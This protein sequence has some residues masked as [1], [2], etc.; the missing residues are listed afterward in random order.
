M[1]GTQRIGP[2]AGRTSAIYRTRITH[3]RRAAAHHYFEHRSYCWYVDVDNLPRLPRWLR[4]AAQFDARDHFSGADGESLRQRVDSFLAARG[5]T[6]PGGRITALL[7]ARVFG[8]AFNPLSIYWCHDRD[9]VLRHVVAE[10]H[11]TRGER[12]AYLLPPADDPALVTKALYASP[13]HPVDGH[14]LVRAP[15]PEKH[16]DVTISLHRGDQPAFVATLRGSR[17]RASAGTLLGLQLVAPLAPLW[18]RLDMRVQAA[19]L[20]LRGVPRFP[21]RPLS[22]SVA[23]ASRPTRCVDITCLSGQSV[24]S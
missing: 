6:V 1:E 20:W 10:V 17:R 11:N 18:A 24:A 16:L 3:L 5:A 12:H 9:G 4:A 2:L 14:Y 22:P 13:F 19:A 15:R 8:Y 23:P 21:W 7:Q